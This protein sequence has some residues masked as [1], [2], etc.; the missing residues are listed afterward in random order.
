MID[1][2]KSKIFTYK[3]NTKLFINVL[4]WNTKL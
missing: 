2:H 1:V 3:V 4:P